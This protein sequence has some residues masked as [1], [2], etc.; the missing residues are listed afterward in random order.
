MNGDGL[1]DL[2]VGRG[3]PD[4]RSTTSTH[5]DYVYRNET[6]DGGPLQ[7][8]EA[9]T[10][11][12]GST[13]SI[14]WGDTNG[15][16]KVD[17]LASGGQEVRVYPITSTLPAAI[18]S[19][20]PAAA[21]SITLPVLGADGKPQP[22]DKSK[23]VID[24]GDVDGD[25]YPDLAVGVPVEG[26]YSAPAR[27][28]R[29]DPATGQLTAVWQ[30]RDS[31]AATSLSWGDVDNDGDPDLVIGYSGR[32][33]Q[34]YVNDGGKLGEQPAWS[35]GNDNTGKPVVAWADVDGD[36]DLDLIQTSRAAEGMPVFIYLNRG[37]PLSTAPSP[38]AGPKAENSTAAAW[39]DV[40]GDGRL[41]LA[42][43]RAG[44]G[45]TTGNVPVGG[46]PHPCGQPDLQGGG[47]QAGP[48][49]RAV[50]AGERRGDDQPGVGR[51]ERRRRVGPGRRQ[52]TRG[53]P[54]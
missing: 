33:T 7:F 13:V 26:F 48:C 5:K 14:G 34:L 2:A 17:A 12:A 8:S 27:V 49:T 1:L 20:V 4:Q 29:S 46:R 38:G 24:W 31:R 3:D 54:G 40:D 22:A 39:G 19:T 23:A 37:R 44:N 47:R 10:S 35:S 15:D 21:P 41:E 52:R 53:S 28:Y 16:G 51:R 9:W 42:I 11:P 43:G 50:G 45:A 36:S 30:A 18:T 32:P 6:A 25:G